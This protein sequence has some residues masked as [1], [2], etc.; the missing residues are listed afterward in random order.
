MDFTK[1]TAR[2]IARIGRQ[3]QYTPVGGVA[4]TITADFAT[5]P[6]EFVGVEGF[7]PTV[8]CSSADVPNAAHGDIFVDGADTWKAVGKDIDK[9]SGVTEFRV[10]L[11]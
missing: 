1:H 6:R 10:E 3:V 9:R 5:P 2:V 4:T 8:K 11:Q 7:A